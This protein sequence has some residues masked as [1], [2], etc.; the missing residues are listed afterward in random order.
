MGRK[1]GEV[2]EEKK[3]VHIKL[4][5]G[6][7]ETLLWMLV[8]NNTCRSKS[9]PWYSRKWRRQPNHTW[10]EKV[11]QAIITV[12]AYFNDSQ[13][14][15][16]KGRRKIAGLEVLQ[17]INEPTAASLAYGLA[18]T[19]KDEKIAVYD[20]GGGHLPTYP[21]WSWEKV[22]SSEIHQRFDTHLGGDDFGPWRW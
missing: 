8:A 18:K 20:L 22:Y 10:G 21:S 13:R 11:T 15:G 14:Q 4:Y 6:M 12:P 3:K 2:T 16:H 17:E 5:K 9:L 7:V 19:K 1:Y